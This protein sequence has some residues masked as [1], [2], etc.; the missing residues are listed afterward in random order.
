MNEPKKSKRGF[1]SMDPA[2]LRSVAR[3]GGSAVPAEKRTF[4]I[5]AQLAS[6]AGRKGGLAVDPT[7]RTFA[8]DHDAAAKAGRKGGM[9]T[10]NRSSDQ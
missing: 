4:S 9:A 1:A 10:R 2:L 8:R 7:K 3:K 5:N 6:E